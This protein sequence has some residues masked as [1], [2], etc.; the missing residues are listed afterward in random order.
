MTAR[1]P[2]PPGPRATLRLTLWLLAVTNFAIGMGGF[3]V[4]GILSPVAADL[5][6]S[7]AQAGSLMTV[8][9]FFY[10]IGSPLGVALTGHWDR[11]RVLL[12]GMLV[13]VAGSALAVMAGSLVTVWLARA[14]MALGAGL[15]TPVAAAVAAALS[16]TEQRGR[17]L[18]VVFGGLTLAQALGVPV[19][20]WLGY[21]LGWRSAF[22][23]VAVLGATVWLALRLRLP[24]R[25]MVPAASL[26]ALGAVLACRPQTLAVSFTALFIGALYV[27]YTYIAPMLEQRYGLGRDGVSLVLLVFGIGAVVGNGVGGWLT[28]RI[29]GRRTLAILCAAQV[30][31]L[32]AVTLLH[33]PLLALLLLTAVWS[34]CGW[35]FMVAQQARLVALA[36]ERVPVLFA[37]NASFLYA[38]ST[39]GSALGGLV[40]RH[41]GFDALGP[42]AALL[43]VLAGAS[44]WSR[45][46]V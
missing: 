39:L 11:K 10:A 18:A 16:P 1:A 26:R 28:D 3:V 27:V 46:R 14:V 33:L 8:Y 41:Q 36:P 9:A 42:V 38:G 30:L 17:A 35:S 29:G 2:S 37:L 19:G 21:T 13:F 7:K 5:A 15:V 32:C 31:L 45:A 6:I 40:L 22:V 23:V 24:E 34:V 43:M 4:I 25:I 12:A 44:L 20:A